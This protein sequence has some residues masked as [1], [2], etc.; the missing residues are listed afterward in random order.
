VLNKIDM[1]GDPEK[2]QS[3]LDGFENAVAISALKGIGMSELL[4]EVSGRLFETFSQIC[5][6]LPYS[7]AALISAFHEMGQVERIEH[8]RGGVIIEGNVPGR[9]LARFQPFQMKR[10]SGSDVEA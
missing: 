2:A 1:L 3:A 5:V 8:I 7:E 4:A 6:K 9:L 10:K